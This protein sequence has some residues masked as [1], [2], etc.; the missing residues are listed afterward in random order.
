[1]V[2]IAGLEENLFPHSRSVQSDSMMEE[3]RRLCYVA[4]TRAEKKLFVSWARYRRRF[5]GGPAEASIR[6]R[7]LREVPANLM[8]KIGG[9]AQ[10]SGSDVSLL[11]ERDLVRETVKKNLYTGKTYNSIENIQQFFNERGMPAPRGITSQQGA[12]TK[13]AAPK[14]PPRADVPA[15]GPPRTFGQAPGPR[16]VVPISKPGAKFRSG[17]TVVHPK[18]GRGTIL[19]R[20]GD[21][22]DAK[23]T[24]SFPGYGLKKI[25]EKFAGI[26]RDE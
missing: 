20:E 17:A 12:N 3:E 2:F 7:F 14:F 13:P 10:S 23:L 1:V 6:S 19:Q 5:G 21:G 16:K 26:Q 9:G 18:W 8:E 11:A 22:D 24:I 4:M 25:L 15:G